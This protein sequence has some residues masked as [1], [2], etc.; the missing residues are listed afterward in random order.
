MLG[1]LFRAQTLASRL[2]AA[3]PCA[4]ARSSLAAFFPARSLFVAMES[5]PNPDSLKFVPEDCEVLP[6]RLGSGMHFGSAAEAR[7]SKMVRTLLKHGDI[8][9]VF[10]GRDF[11][12]VNKREAAAWP[13]LKVIIVDAIMDAYAELEAKGTPIIDEAPAAEDTLVLPDDSEV[14]AMIKELIETRI[15]PAVQED[16]GDIFFV[17]VRRRAAAR[18][19][20]PASLPPC[21]L[22]AP[23]R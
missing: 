17:C 22:P 10:L 3:L 20:S 15:R 2:Q 16:G 21:S 23:L 7:G 18:S 9:G 19:G 13:A 6:E 8:T 12:S 4:N 5:T 1:R 14:V 11:I